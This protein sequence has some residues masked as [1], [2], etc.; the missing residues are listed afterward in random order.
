M[1]VL[2]GNIPLPEN[3]F[4]VDLNGAL[5]TSCNLKH[6]P[7]DFWQMRGDYDIVHLHFPEYATFELE[8]AYQTGLSDELIAETQTRLQYWS[9]H[10]TLVITRHV[11]LPH[12]ALEDTQWEKMYECFYRYS[13]GVVH[14]A[15]ASVDDFRERY[16]TTD[17]AGGPPRHAIVPHHN[18]VTLPNTVPRDEARRQL[19]ITD[20][21]K[22]VLVFG[23]IRNDAEIQL[24]ETAFSGMKTKNKMLLVSRWRERLPNISWIRLKYLLRDL[25]RLYYRI[26]PQYKFNYSFVAEADTQLYLNAADVLFIPRLRVLNSGNVTLGMTFGKVVVGPNSWDVG[27]LLTETGNVVFD[28][29]NIHSAAEA[30]DAAMQLAEAKAVGIENRRLAL[31]EWPVQK[32]ANG[33]LNFFKQ[34]LS[35]HDKPS[36]ASRE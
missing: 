23:T 12:D 26:H 18:Y 32:C 33:Y 30:L 8:H 35:E 5:E 9:E 31:E 20:G 7:D 22:V 19:G 16:S 14:F 24:I 25:K 2:V 17:F 28:P 15:Q 10:S 34:L 11:L 13:R 1:K 6:D 36:A 27:Q 3:R 4:L 29:D 21:K